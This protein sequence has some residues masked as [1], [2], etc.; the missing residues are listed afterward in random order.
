MWINTWRP[1]L[2]SRPT[3]A[4]VIRINRAPAL[5]LWAAIVAERLGFDWGEALTLGQAAA[6]LNAHAKGVRLGLFESIP[7]AER[8]R[9]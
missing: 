5:R 6:G 9:P 8:E 4:T 3:M 1:R 7:V 2:C